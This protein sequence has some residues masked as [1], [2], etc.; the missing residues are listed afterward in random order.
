LVER[1]LGAEACLFL[2][3][4]CG[5]VGPVRATTDFQD[6]GL[7]GRALGGEALRVLSLLEARDVPPMPPALTVANEIVELERRPLPDE[8]ALQ[9]QARDLEAMIHEAQTD[10]AQREAIA[11]YRRVAEPLRL[12]QLGGGPVRME[13][14]AVR[15][16]DALIVACEGELFVE[17]GNR[18]KEASPA[19]V[20]FVAAYANGYEGYIPTPEAWDE[21]GYEPSLGPWTRVWRDG[22]EVLAERA[23]ALAKRVWDLTPSPPLH[24][25]ERGSCDEA[26]LAR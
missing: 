15:L 6:V 1:E 2:Q 3:G 22:G 26:A 13:V 20:T 18:I 21:G 17:Y 25:V 16:G 23:V 24:R 11:A 4:A 10:A 8:K 7:Y 19:A 14:Q 9:T 12:A 5:N